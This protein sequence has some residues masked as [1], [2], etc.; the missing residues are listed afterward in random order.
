MGSD[1]GALRGSWRG[2]QA[3]DFVEDAL[4]DFAFAHARPG[5]VAAVAGKQGDDVGVVVESS[6]FGGDIVGDNQVG[7]LG[8]KFLSR[9]FR[10]VLGLRGKAYD[11]SVAFVAGH[12]GEDIRR[13]FERAGRG[14]SLALDF[15]SLRFGEPIVPHRGAQTPDAQVPTSLTNTPVTFV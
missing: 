1:G 10:D 4:R 14:F 15:L 12:A 13:G 3:D 2:A 6:A 7:I 11:E 8:G 9:V 5:E